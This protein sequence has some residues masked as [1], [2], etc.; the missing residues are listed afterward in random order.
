M[1]QLE[2]RVLIIGLDGLRPDQ[3]DARLM[4][5]CAKL[6][7]SG[8]HFENFYAAY[9][10]HTRVNMTTLTTGVHPGRH[11]VVSNLMYVPGAGDAGLVDTSNDRHLLSFKAQIGEPF[12][13]APTLGD[14]LHRMGKRL[15]GA[16]SS[17]AGASLLWNINHPYRMINPASH[18]GEA[19]LSQVLEKLG[20]VPEEANRSKINRARWATQALIDVLLD[21]PDNQVLLLWLSE[22]DSSQHF[23]GLG[24]PEAKEALRVVDTCV[25][26]VIAAIETVGIAD[27][28]DVLL[29]SDHG[30]TSVQAHQSLREYLDRARAELPLSFEPLVA[31]DF[32]YANNG[33]AANERDMN[34]LVDW[35]TAQDWCDLIFIHDDYTN[36]DNTLPLHLAIQT[37]HHNRAPL[38]A[39][40]PK[41]SH[42]A[43]S[44]GVPGTVRALTSYAMLKSTHG[45]AAPYDLRA[46]CIG[47]GPS[48]KAGEVVSVPHGTVDIAPTVA[49]LLGLDSNEPFEG[50]PLL[51]GLLELPPG[52][53]NG[54]NNVEI[55][56]HATRDTHVKIAHVGTTRY[57]LGS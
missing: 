44:F 37:T 1:Q 32:L 42:E 21:D 26:D 50:R 29:I 46:L 24:S 5:T 56:E 43:N 7:Q 48:F 27:Q 12:V 13:L 10:S 8:T 40:S 16:A 55:I 15:A 49:H 35:L 52:L 57:F 22:P 41:W 34:L 36:I 45:S 31:G 30:H 3:F 54:E 6:M 2:K 38:L 25:A 51:E 28:L 20:P 19:D 53:E 9:P 18:Y 4:P 39:V 33:I 14:R 17:S 11:G 23:Y 47:Y